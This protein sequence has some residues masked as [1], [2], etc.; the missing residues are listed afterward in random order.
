MFTYKSNTIVLL[1]PTTRLK[2]R[3][4]FCIIAALLILSFLGV[5]ALPTHESSVHAITATV[6]SGI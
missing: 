6:N 4:A 2:K 5:R 3:I 1:N